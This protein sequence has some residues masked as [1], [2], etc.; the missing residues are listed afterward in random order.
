M[1]KDLARSSEKLVEQLLQIRKDVR[2]TSS[3]LLIQARAV[4]LCGL[5]YKTVDD[6]VVERSTQAMPWRRALLSVS[7][8]AF[9]SS[10]VRG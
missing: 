3:H 4:I 9:F 10:M 2:S 1:E 5:P 8:T 7:Q 6:R